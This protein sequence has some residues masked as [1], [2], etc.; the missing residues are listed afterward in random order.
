[1]SPPGAVA[2][3]LAAALAAAG[4]AP[5][6]VL[7]VAPRPPASPAI[8]SLS[9]AVASQLARSS[10][11]AVVPDSELRAALARERVAGELDLDAPA[12]IGLALRLVGADYLVQV[13]STR[14]LIVRS[15]RPGAPSGRLVATAGGA[16]QDVAMDLVRQLDRPIESP[17]IAPPPPLPRAGER[18]QLELR[19]AGGADLSASEDEYSVAVGFEVPFAFR[20]ALGGTVGL[21]LGNATLGLRDAAL[22]DGEVVAQVDSNF[23]L[24]IAVDLRWAFLKGGD[25]LAQAAVGA[26]IAYVGLTTSSAADAS[27]LVVPAEP[28]S[29]GLTAGPS[30]A[31]QL[32][33]S[34]SD[35]FQVRAGARYVAAF[36]VSDPVIFGTEAQTGRTLRLEAVGLLRHEL[37][38]FVAID[39]IL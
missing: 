29:Y 13:V 11:R 22:P 34:M 23:R 10:R 32:G 14:T 17:A 26:E 6:R 35:R 25:W 28:K 30:L 19:V 33:Y 15:I 24:P 21:Q 39:L 8:T 38:G 2:L 9:R 16:P 20:W 37:T 36:L 7:V 4:A 5:E 1:M 27:G 12:D 3:L 18:V 31:L